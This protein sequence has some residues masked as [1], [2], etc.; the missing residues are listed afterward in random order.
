MYSGSRGEVGFVEFADQSQGTNEVCWEIF[1]VIEKI[2]HG[3]LRVWINRALTLETL[4]D[5]R[6]DDVF[7]VLCASPKPPASFSV[8][9]FLVLAQRYLR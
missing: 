7:V 9:L 5:R 2:C 1:G 4:S 8:S 3:C 6:H